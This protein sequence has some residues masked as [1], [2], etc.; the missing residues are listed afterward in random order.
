MTPGWHPVPYQ[1]QTPLE[2]H[3]RG[4]L[5]TLQVVECILHQVD[6]VVSILLGLCIDQKGGQVEDFFAG[7]SEVVQ[8]LNLT[9][10]INVL[11]RG[12]VLPENVQ[13]GHGFGHFL[14]QC[15][16]QFNNLLNLFPPGL[17]LMEM[18]DFFLGVIGDLIYS[19]VENPHHVQ[20][21]VEGFLVVDT[22]DD[23]VHEGI[24]VLS[25]EID[26]VGGIVLGLHCFPFPCAVSH[27]NHGH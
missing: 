4:V 6:D 13:D 18:I 7:G 20:G 1:P 5:C 11:L 19:G 21:N 24:V 14:V 3:S 16:L 8:V 9:A 22:I 25:Q 26:E 2:H 12:A 27:H 17:S 23:A 10:P 15:L